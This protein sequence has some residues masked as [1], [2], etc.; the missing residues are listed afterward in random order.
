MNLSGLNVKDPLGSRGGETSSLCGYVSDISAS[1]HFPGDP[2]LFCN[3][4]HGECLV[5][6]PEF[7]V[8]ALLVV[9]V[10]ENTTVQQCSVYIR[11]HGPDV[12]SRV[13]RL[14]LR[15]ELDR[16]EIVDYWWVEVDRVSFVEGV[17]L[18]SRRD[19]DLRTNQ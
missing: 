6:K 8:L 13:W 9:G 18:S 1:S 17:N 16:V 7:T 4:G 12:P 15:R 10:T 11:H 14:A 5:E 2:Y 19:L 3:V